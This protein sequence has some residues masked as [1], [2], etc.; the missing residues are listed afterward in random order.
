MFVEQGAR[1]SARL[2]KGGAEIWI[3]LNSA[4]GRY[5]AVHIVERGAMTQDVTVDAAGMANDIR[6]TGKVALYG[7]YFDVDKAEVKP[8]SEPALK[9]IATLLGDDPKLRIYVVGHT[10]STGAFDHNVTLSQL[11]A[12]AVAKRLVAGFGIAPDRLKPFGVGAV[13]PVASNDTDEGKARNRRVEL[14]KQ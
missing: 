8:E 5:Y 14:V 6:A 12:E 3:D 7:I 2:P 13:A 9:E 11:R 10:D 1:V 4:S